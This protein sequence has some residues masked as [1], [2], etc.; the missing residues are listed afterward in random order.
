MTKDSKE[1]QVPF[2][3][4][5]NIFLGGLLSK[6]GVG[7]FGIG[8]IFYWVFVLNADASFIHFNGEVVTVDGVVQGVAK[9]KMPEVYEIHYKF[10]NENGRKIGA[11]SYSTGR[12]A[13]EGEIV[14]VEYPKG[15]SLYS[16]IQGMRKKC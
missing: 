4:K 11:V 15:K 14:T 9:A 8:M 13:S 16:R 10:V 1:R 7:W 6:A 3:V 5:V 12:W 2:T